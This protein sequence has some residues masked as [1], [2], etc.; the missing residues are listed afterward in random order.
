MGQRAAAAGV[1]GHRHLTAQPVEQ[2]DGRI[3][4]VGPQHVLH[5]P[6]QQKHPHPPRALRRIGPAHPIV[7]PRRK[8]CRREVQHGPDLVPEH[9]GKRPRQSRPSEGQAGP[10]G[11]GQNHRNGAAQQPLEP[12]PD[13]IL[14]D[15]NPRVVH[16][17]LIVDPGRTGVHAGEAGQAAVH[18]MHDFVR[19]PA[20][21]LQHVLDHVDASA[22]AVPLIAEQRVGRAG[23]QA[24]PAMNAVP[25]DG[26]GLHDGG[27]GELGLGET[28]LHGSDPRIHPARIQDP[29]RIEA[30]LDPGR[31]GG[32]PGGKLLEDGDAAAD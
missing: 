12:R 15:M 21:R 3:I 10:A 17:V 26:V 14:L 25:E 4:D 24:E 6:R 18:V 23:R 1:P 13:V 2:P 11:M 32:H 22:R 16:I 31:Q 5:A 30:F 29:L 27:F 20:A 19:R 8:T 9:P 7:R 28:G